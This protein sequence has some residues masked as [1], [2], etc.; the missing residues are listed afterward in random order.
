MHADAKRVCVRAVLPSLLHLQELVR[1]VCVRK[2]LVDEE[3]KSSVNAYVV[4]KD[5]ASVDKV[6]GYELQIPRKQRE[7]WYLQYLV[8]IHITIQQQ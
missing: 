8:Y 7:L 1:K 6:S 5:E 2:G 4:Y 3:V